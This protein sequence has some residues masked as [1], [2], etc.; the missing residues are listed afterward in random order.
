MKSS[1]KNRVTNIGPKEQWASLLGGGLLAGA[2]IAT[3]SL[4][5]AALAALGG[6]LMWRGA[7]R[8]CP[9]KD[10]LENKGPVRIDRSFTVPDK[11]PGEVYNF[12]RNLEN[13]P[14]V[15]GWIKSVQ[16]LDERRSHWTAK[17]PAGVPIDWDAE[18]TNDRSGHI[19]EWRSAPGSPL[20]MSG[21]VRFKPKQG[22]GTR[23]HV[24]IR[25][26]GSG[27]PL[28]ELLPNLLGELPE[29]RMDQ[30]IQDLQGALARP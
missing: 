1:Q 9:L 6:A 28:G 13:L 10:A 30:G 8:H 25:Y 12:W 4:P 24:S 5:G 20:E 18:I 16:V 14:K 23:V 26:A 2:G 7:T 19:I 21:A 22:G 15:T 29:R 11:S 3:R 27:G 17:G